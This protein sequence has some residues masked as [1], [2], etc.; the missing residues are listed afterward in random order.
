[1]QNCTQA[2]RPVKIAIYF[3]KELIPDNQI[4]IFQK[5]EKRMNE[6]LIDSYYTLASGSG[7]FITDNGNLITNYHVINTNSIGMYINNIS[8][9][10]TNRISK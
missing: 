6:K 1:M 4:P 7:F 9:A 8:N 10:F 2:V 5:I 3:D